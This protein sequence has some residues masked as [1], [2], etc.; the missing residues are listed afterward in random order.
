MILGSC[1]SDN[2]G[3]KFLD[4]KFQVTANPFGAAY[5]PV[6]ILK[7]LKKE[8]SPKYI[9]KQQ[10]IYYH[11]DVHGAISSTNKADLISQIELRAKQTHDR[12]KEADWL[13]L[14][15]GSA[16]VYEHV[17]NNEIV[18]NCH[19]APRG[20]FRK[21]L[22]S[23][24]EIIEE[25]NSAI[26]VF[27]R[28]NGRL[29]ILMTVSPVRHISDGL[30]ENNLS[31]SILLQAVHEIVPAHDNIHYFPAYEIMVDELRDYRFYNEDMIHPGR[32][33]IQYIWGKLAEAH[34]D[35]ETLSFVEKWSRIKKSMGHKP[36]HPHS[37]QYQQFLK[38]TIAALKQFPYQID[39][40]N[41]LE[42]LNDRLK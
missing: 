8:T 4:Y 37:A 34:F 11:W 2:I 7:V 36:F 6:S 17:R 20:T 40:A 30:I 42:K 22:L 3:E 9:T 23:V 28:R 32:Q 19:R 33:A 1:F 38:K 5:N 41:E 14:T 29:N 26:K 12:L 35:Q 31:K 24:N 27:S 21:R 13:I 10:G 16:H 15:F 25:F 18:A 39:C